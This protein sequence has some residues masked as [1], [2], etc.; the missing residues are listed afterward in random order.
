MR[1]G[2]EFTRTRVGVYVCERTLAAFVFSSSERGAVRLSSPMKFALEA[3]QCD[4]ETIMRGL[5]RSF[6]SA[7][8]SA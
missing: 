5:P 4:A 2:R 6:S 8:R 1:W 7:L 3:L